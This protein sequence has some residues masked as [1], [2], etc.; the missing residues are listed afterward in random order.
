MAGTLFLDEVGEIPLE[1]Q[2]KLLRVL[3]E[4]TYE[5][6]GDDRD[7]LPST[8][9]S[10][11]RRIATCRP[12]S[13]KGNFREDL[14]YRLTVFPMRG[15]TPTRTPGRRAP[16]GR[17][18]LRGA[19]ARRDASA[20]RGRAAR[21][22]ENLRVLTHYPWP[23]NVRELQ[24]VIERALIG[25][26]GGKLV[27]QPPAAGP[28]AGQPAEASAPRLL[29]NEQMRALERENLVAV[30]NHHRWKVAGKGG[31]AEFLGLHPATLNS[32]LKAMGLER[33]RQ[34]P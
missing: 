17:G 34:S 29:S 30:L 7:A 6:V 23:G 21:T 16:A 25:A 33:P 2:G 26:R 15:A 9:A 22:P 19:V 27:V 8:C 24:N 11:P 28:A 14:Y 32:R 12:R 5:R 3:Q 10:W 20:R 13:R 31:A 4:G 1:L 18:T